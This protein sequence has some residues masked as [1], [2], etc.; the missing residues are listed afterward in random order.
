MN[1]SPARMRSGRFWRPGTSSCPPVSIVVPVTSVLKRGKPSWSTKLCCRCRRR[2]HRR[3]CS[4]QPARSPERSSGSATAMPWRCTRIRP[5][6]TSILVVKAEDEYGRRLHVDKPMLRE[7]RE[8]FAR[9]M[10]EQGIAANATPRVIR[11]RNK[12]KARDGA[13]RAQRRGKSSAIRAKVTMI[14]TELAKNGRFSE[15]ARAK[16]VGNT[17]G[18][19][20]ELDEDRGHAGPTRRG[21]S[22]RR[23]T[24]LREAPSAG[25]HGYGE[26]GREIRSAFGFVSGSTPST[27]DSRRRCARPIT[28]CPP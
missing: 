25:S 27:S 3:R 17:K 28:T 9:T 19:R 8:D 23:R 16:L 26:T 5:T 12:G 20:R 1:G 11:G 24:V 4:L 15:P 7:W 22:R 13:F 14:A 2:P 6:L 21:D 18:R 10:R